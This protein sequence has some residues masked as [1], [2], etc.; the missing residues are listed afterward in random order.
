M[1]RNYCLFYFL[2]ISA[3]AFLSTLCPCMADTTS[4]TVKNSV[5]H[6]AKVTLSTYPL[7]SP[8][9]STKHKPRSVVVYQTDQAPLGKRQPLL[10]V[11]GLRAEYRSQCRWDKVIARLS[12]D[13]RFNEKYKIYVLRYDSTAHLPETVPLFSDAVL[14]LYQNAGRNPIAVLAMSLGGMLT[15]TAMQDPKVDS[16]ISL[17]FAMAT[18]FH[19]SPLFCENWFQYSL[20]KNRSYPLTRIDH[21]LSY[22]IYFARNSN[23]LSDMNWDNCDGLIPEVGSFH[24]R[25]PFGPKGVLTVKNDA[26]QK[27]A[28]LNQDSHINKSKLILYG[29]YLINPY[30][31]PGLR[32]EVE[33][34]ILA[35]YTFITMKVPAHFA[36]EH[37]VLEM[38][39]REISRVIPAKS[40]TIALAT[41]YP[42]G[43]N[44]GISPV[45]SELFLPPQVCREQQLAQE[46][47][48]EL[49]QSK[50]DVHLAR[51]FRNVD[52]LSFLDGYHP[53]HAPKTLQ[54]KLNPQ[55]TARPIS[56]W[57][58]ADLLDA[59]NQTYPTLA[60]EVQPSD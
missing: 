3:G 47:D 36:V 51:V 42:Y 9:Q 27:L 60:K 19:G 53:H 43:L 49:V 8:H 4:N 26:N 45:C 32:E 56:D 33:R 48:I 2:L 12:N 6:T 39:N 10:L 29:G 31:I 57:I 7:M 18:P 40:S 22:R 15:Y 38:L 14:E 30:L 52:H 55:Q 54:D 1:G 59:H 21:S 41:K 13:P 34:T 25:L 11:H 58:L 28:K 5:E 16:A 44:D 17:L 20:Y 35:P 23:L 37:P 46:S 50:I 24:S